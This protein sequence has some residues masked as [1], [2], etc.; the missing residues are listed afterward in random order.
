[1]RLDIG[2]AL[3]LCRAYEVTRAQKKVP[4]SLG[5]EEAAGST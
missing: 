5:P 4:G 3:L 2:C 1:M